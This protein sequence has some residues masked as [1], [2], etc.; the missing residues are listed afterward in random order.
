M[1][2]SFFVNCCV[3]KR[4]LFVLGCCHLEPIW[5][6]VIKI[7]KHSTKMVFKSNIQIRWK[8][9][10]TCILNLSLLKVNLTITSTL[11]KLDPFDE[12]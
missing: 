7:G 6:A 12:T 8:N 9:T 2:H 1:C 5:C 3:E 11:P 4:K 10:K